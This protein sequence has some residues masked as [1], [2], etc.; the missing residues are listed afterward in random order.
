MG[1]N[2]VG[3][4]FDEFVVATAVSRHVEVV[5]DELD[6]VVDAA[7]AVAVGHAGGEVE[8]FGAAAAFDNFEEKLGEADGAG[9]LGSVL[10]E[11]EVCGAEG[12]IGQWVFDGPVAGEVG[13]DRG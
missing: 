5:A 10:L 8:G 11:I 13:G 2:A 12:A 6:F 4:H 7:V 1:G 9:D 3:D